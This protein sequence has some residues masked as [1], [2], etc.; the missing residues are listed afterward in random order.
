MIRSLRQLFVLLA[1]LALLAAACGD[2]DD[3]GAE[4]DGDEVSTSVAAA[5]DSGA[6][7]TGT[8]DS[9]G[10]PATDPVG[11]V[12]VTT[13]ILGD[14]V[15]QLVGGQLDVITIM[16][17]GADPH[18]FSPSAQQIAQMT[19][20]AVLITNG[21]SFEEG[22]LDIIETAEGDGVAVHEAI[23][24]VSTVEFGEA[25]HDDHG[26]E[27]EEAHSDEEGH[28]EHEGEEGHDE[29]EG[30]EGHEDEHG[31]EGEEAKSEDED[32]D[33]EGEEGHDEHDHSGEDPHFFT[34]PA[35]M[36]VAVHG[37]ADFLIANVAGIDAAALET[38]AD[39][40]IAEL[41]AL[42]AEVV[43]ILA[44]VDAADRV[45]VTNHEVFGYF[46]DRYGFEVAGAVIPSGSTAEGADARALAEL[47]ELIEAEG[48]AA[49]FADTSSSDELANTLAAEVGDIAV[50]ELYSESLGD[51]GSDGATYV[52]MIRT[53]A[54]RIAAALA[55]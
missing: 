8:A 20:A 24:G 11:T 51:S 7:D 46:A 23:T 39:A 2:T 35:R 50:V 32:H 9:E 41:A 6:A 3:G 38:S 54:Q 53:N 12:V 33:H 28:D 10:A 26:H 52:D 34:D 40:Y 44:V 42:D 4:A 15:T 13:N 21:A 5:D 17:V 36:A 31:H 19:E 18:D 22:L 25:G 30:E 49:I 47:A 37:I 14:V 29:H 16:P 45:L 48:V 1:A 27:G 55:G 43:E